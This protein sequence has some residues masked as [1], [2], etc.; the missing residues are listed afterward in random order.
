MASSYIWRNP[1][2]RFRWIH[3]AGRAHDASFPV[4]E[5]GNF[6]LVPDWQRVVVDNRTAHTIARDVWVLIPVAPP[7]R[8]TFGGS[9]DWQPFWSR[10]VTRWPGCP[11]AT[12]PAIFSR[13]RSTERR[14]RRQCSNG[15]R[16]KAISG[17]PADGC[18][19]AFPSRIGLTVRIRAATSGCSRSMVRSRIAIA[20]TRTTALC[21][22]W[23]IFVD[24]ESDESGQ[25]ECSFNQLRRLGAASGHSPSVVVLSLRGAAMAESCITVNRVV[26]GSADY[27]V[28]NTP[29]AWGRFV[30]F[31][32]EDRC[33]LEC[34][35]PWYNHFLVWQ[36]IPGCSRLW[37]CWTGTARLRTRSDGSPALKVVLPG[38]K[39]I[40]HHLAQPMRTWIASDSGCSTACGI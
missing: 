24:L 21:S 31:P 4:G 29:C 3:C 5:Y 30:C 2:P 23:R 35:I 17:C 7:R 32:P 33:R 27:T 22:Y 8:V 16:S 12:A 15:V 6:R 1:R 18:P 13:R 10:T 9:D 28:D 19:M 38:R 40:H 14:Q 11:T 25:S 20:A 36:V 26:D 39:R 37:L 34:C